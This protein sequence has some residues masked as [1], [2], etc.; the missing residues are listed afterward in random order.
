M[1]K[2]TTS[3]PLLAGV[4][5]RV[6]SKGLINAAA[7]SSAAR[8]EGERKQVMGMLKQFQDAHPDSWEDPAMLGSLL[9]RLR[10][11]PVVI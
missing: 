2:W 1:A 11:R 10:N 4:R 9:K 3:D 7:V 6:R 5:R 8:S